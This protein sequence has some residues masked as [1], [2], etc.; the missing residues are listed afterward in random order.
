MS[1]PT[2]PEIGLAVIA[3]VAL[4]VHMFFFSTPDEPD[5]AKARIPEYLKT[6]IA[7][8]SWEKDERKRKR[9]E[10]RRRSGVILED[11]SLPTARVDSPR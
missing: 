8:R 9:R 2:A 4:V 1:Q 5:P 11:H 6:G 3:V 7:Y 10:R